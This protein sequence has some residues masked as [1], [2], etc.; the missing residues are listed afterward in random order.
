VTIHLPPNLYD[1]TTWTGLALFAFFSVLDH[2]TTLV[3]SQ[4]SQ[5]HCRLGFLSQNRNFC[6]ESL[7]SYCLT[8]EDVSLL[9]LGGFMWLSYMPRGQ[10]PKWLSRCSSI[11]AEISDCQG[12]TVHKCGL[13]L[14]YQN[15]EEEFKETIKLFKASFSNNHENEAKASTS[16]S[17]NDED[18]HPN[19]DFD[20]CLIYNSCFPQSEVINWFSHP[21]NGPRV[22]II[23]PPNLYDDTTWTGLALFAF[24]SVLDH[25]TTLV[26]S[27]GS[28]VHCRLGF[29]SQNRNF[30]LES[31]H[32]YCLTEEDI[33]L[34]KLGGFMWL[35]YIPRGWF[36][37]WLNRCSSIDAEINDCSIEAEIN[38]CPGLTVH[39]CGLHLLYQI[40][41][42]E[43]KETIRLCQASF[44][45]KHE[46]DED[47]H[48]ARLASNEDL[49][50]ETSRR[51]INQGESDEANNQ[52][53]KTS[54]RLN[55]HRKLMCY[56]T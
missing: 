53:C 26:G 10:F 13:H 43:F 38:D 28:Q 54:Q 18:S 51:P 23:L 47:S 21:S 42:E 24:F 7:H 19:E 36:P 4:G 40:N 15:D 34:L 8:E 14:L 17:A 3:G 32:S 11:K 6:L 33:S 31:L 1:D 16:N 20:R 50:N 52:L 39:K 37:K 12:L 2:S 49:H 30:C 27:Q 46:N 35:S 45:N 29:L 25:S 48:P 41:E 44:S 9:K 5:V 56:Q 22:T 55:V